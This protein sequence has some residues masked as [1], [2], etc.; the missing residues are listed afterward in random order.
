MV[1]LKEE[2]YDYRFAAAV[3]S[4]P[5]FDGVKKDVLEAI[6]AVDIP[7]LDPAKVTTSKSGGVKKRHRDPTIAI[8]HD[9]YLLFPVNQNE[10]NKRLNKE[11]ENRDWELQPEIVPK[12][13]G[14]SQ[15]RL[16]A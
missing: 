5:A 8:P 6:H 13:S 3:L 7:L 4:D 15:P 9:R 11:F 1:H 14:A 2:A 12:G 16:K 10:L